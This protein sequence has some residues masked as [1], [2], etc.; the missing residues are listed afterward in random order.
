MKSWLEID[1]E[2]LRK[3][4]GQKDKVFLLNELISNAWDA[5]ITRVEVTLS[6]PDERGHSWLR[7]TDNSPT[8]W[9]KLSDS[10]TM[11]AE[12]SKK[13][14]SEKRGR[15]NAGCKDVL[16]CA[17]EATLTTV[18]GQV[19]FNEDQSR[20]EGTETREVGSEYV[21][22]FQLTLEE[23][24]HICNRAKLLLPPEGVTTI[25]NGE[26]ITY[27]KPIGGFTE[28]LPSVLADK[29]GV[30]RNT[31]RQADVTL[32]DCLPGEVATIYEMG[33]PIVELGDDKWHVNVGQKVPLSRDRDNVNPAY[34]K[35]IRTAVFNARF[36]EI[37]KADAGAAWVS[38]AMG[39]AKSTDDAVK[40]VMTARYGDK[41]VTRDV[42]DIG[43]AKEVVSRGG[44]VVEGAS[45]SK[46]QWARLKNVEK[47]K[48]G[49]AY[50]Q[51]SAQV[52]PTDGLFDLGETEFIDPSD[53]TAAMQAYAKFVETIAPRLI[54]LPVTVRYIDD[55]DVF[56]QGC[57]EK[58]KGSGRAKRNVKR[59][60]GKM[61]VNLAYHDPTSSRDNYFLLLHE[62]AH[63]KLYS[64]DHLARIFYDEVTEL[65]AKMAIL[66][67][68]EPKLFRSRKSSDR[69]TAELVELGR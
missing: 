19:R 59:N 52:A 35:K 64:N 5:N 41:W 61:T 31:D 12:S 23:F 7:V 63:N 6:R 69:E 34:L 40:H 26:E 29:E 25:F 14:L 67:L 24:E 60:F 55:E 62:L 50:V 22:R 66:A 44:I 47:N 37:G 68:A 10:Y 33:I 49:T 28:T 4:L 38:E 43:S 30:L 54:D 36:G 56:I 2:G 58:E 46:E 8:G 3:S 65:G 57:F 51:T 53:W 39:S 18:T 13:D 45:M 11:F 9:S 27:R 20:T 1:K 21:G 17:I 42:R 15:F 48:D 16:A 32:Y